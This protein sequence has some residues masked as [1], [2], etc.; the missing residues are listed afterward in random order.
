MLDDIARAARAAGGRAL[1][2]G[3]CVRDRLLEREVDDLDV[4]V[5]GL[6]AESLAV[7]LSQFGD[8]IRVGRSY[9][10]IRLRGLNID[11]SVSSPPGPKFKPEYSDLDS[12]ASF[13]PWT[14][15]KVQHA[16][17][18]RIYKDVGLTFVPVV[19]PP[20]PIRR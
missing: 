13:T 3:G 12:H 10:V 9:P 6:D 4:E 17:G 7:L 15:L 1:L 20:A 19:P 18:L 8:P 16:P 14:D 11:F 2:V 5:L